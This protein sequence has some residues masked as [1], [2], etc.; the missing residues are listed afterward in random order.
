MENSR[1]VNQRCYNRQQLQILQYEN[2]S[3]EIITFDV[4]PIHQTLSISLRKQLDNKLSLCKAFK[5]DIAITV[6]YENH[7]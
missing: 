3:D 1:Q 4:G 6:L 5:I 7:N 2:D